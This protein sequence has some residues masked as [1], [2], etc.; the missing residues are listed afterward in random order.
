MPYKIHDIGP[1]L[2]NFV[3][4]TVMMWNRVE[5]R[6]RATKNFDRALKAEV[7][8]ALWMLTKQWQMG[9]FEGDDAGSPVLAKVRLDTTHLTKYKAAAH[10]A[11]PFPEDVP[12]EAQA[13]QMFLPLNVF[14]QN[15]S[16]DLRLMAGRRWK[17]ML[18]DAGLLNLVWDFTIDNFP[19]KL[20]DP[21]SVADAAI[22]AHP[23]TWQ[24]FAA[25][26]DRVA[27][28]IALYLYLK[29]GNKL[30]D[31]PGG[32]TIPTEPDEV[33][34]KFVGWFGQFFLQ[35][36]DPNDNAWLSSQLEYQFACSAPLKNEELILTAKE[37]YHG[38]LD[39][40]NFNLD[41]SVKTLGD[42]A[43]KAPEDV[44]GKTVQ[45]MLPTPV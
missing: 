24:Q 13:E 14:G 37:Y 3:H 10:E 35:P 36:N 4:P 21:T 41:P 30:V 9:E 23:D 6:P 2:E 11:Q 28:G 29:D 17:K 19:V 34:E 31:L 27:D 5:G 32:G 40:Y 33:I 18:K 39:W 25:V 22:C 44:I 26:A 45:T 20:P 8:D 15:I 12:L 1:I 16:L 43:E 7:R 38:H 42:V